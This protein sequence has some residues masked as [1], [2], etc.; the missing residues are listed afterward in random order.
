MLRVWQTRELE[1]RDGQLFRKGQPFTGLLCW[2]DQRDEHPDGEKEHRG[3]VPW[4][5]GQAWYEG[6]T[7]AYQGRFVWGLWHGP[8]REWHADGRLAAEVEYDLGCPIHERR[9]DEDGRLVADRR[10]DESSWE[11]Q[12]T[13][14]LRAKFMEIFGRPPEE[15]VPLPELLRLAAARAEGGPT[16]PSAGG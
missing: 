15:E 5:V 9:W 11:F 4:G 1:D 14:R 13:Q 2:I 7:L 12:H 8:Y 3:G 16:E 10:V 6:G